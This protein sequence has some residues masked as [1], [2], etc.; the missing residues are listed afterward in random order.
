M[1]SQMNAPKGKQQLATLQDVARHA[2][3]S[4][5]AAGRALGNYGRVSSQTRRLALKAARYLN[6]YPNRVARGMKQ[7]L[8]LYRGADRRK[9]MQS[10]FQHYS[11]SRGGYPL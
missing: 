4:V 7:A 5:A 6:Y 3:I 1:N 2:G 11:P 9:H 10:L 8:N